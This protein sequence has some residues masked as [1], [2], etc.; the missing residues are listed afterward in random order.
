MNSSDNLN[1]NYCMKQGIVTPYYDMPF[2]KLGIIKRITISPMIEPQLA[3][4]GLQRFL[5][6]N[7]YNLKIDI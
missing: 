6:D 3:K 5:K 1:I 4:S 7:E 2:D